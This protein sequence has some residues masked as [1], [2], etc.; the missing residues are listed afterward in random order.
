MA[1]DPSLRGLAKTLSLAVQGVSTGQ[2]SPEELRTPM[3][4]LTDALEGVAVGKSSFFSWRSLITRHDPD[5]LELRHIVLVGAV[6]DF[7]QLQAG[8]L[9][10]D[11]IRATAKRL[12][13]DTPHGL[14]VRST[15]T[16]PLHDQEFSSLQQRPRL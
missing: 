8:K 11:A 13:L 2:A 14:R 7:G 6:L 5:T 15:G 3:R 12:P 9:P 1:S 10:I 16:V 4:T